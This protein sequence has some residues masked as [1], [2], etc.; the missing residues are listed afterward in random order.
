[1]SAFSNIFNIIIFLALIHIDCSAQKRPTPEVLRDVLKEIEMESCQEASIC[2]KK[3]VEKKFDL[4]LKLVN[5]TLLCMP[6]FY[7]QSSL[8]NTNVALQF[9]SCDQDF[10][11][12][13]DVTLSNVVKVYLTDFENLFGKSEVK[14]WS[15]NIK[16]G[17]YVQFDST[18]SSPFPHYFISG[19]LGFVGSNGIP[20]VKM[21]IVE[22]K[23]R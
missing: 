3:I 20:E 7:G 13:L 1:M 8:T 15:R 11:W 18:Q 5:D 12:K 17:S 9:D 2:I 22:Y 23:R 14:E 19:K 21:V 6:L 10:Q 16:S 4:E